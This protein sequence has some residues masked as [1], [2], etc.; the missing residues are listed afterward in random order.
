MNPFEQLLTQE[1]QKRQRQWDPAARW[2][3]IQDT[4][5]WAEQQATVRRNTPEVCREIERKMLL[6]VERQLSQ[7]SEAMRS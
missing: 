2:K 1:E 3:A 4:I 6:L 7:Q 5:T